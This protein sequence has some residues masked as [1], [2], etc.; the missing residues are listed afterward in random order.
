MRCERT[1]RKKEYL[2]LKVNPASLVFPP[3]LY[4]LFIVLIQFCNFLANHFSVSSRFRKQWE[5]SYPWRSRSGIGAVHPNVLGLLYN[6]YFFISLPV[7][8]LSSNP[9]D[10]APPNEQ[11]NHQ[12]GSVTNSLPASATAKVLMKNPFPFS[13]VYTEAPAN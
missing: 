12:T 8:Y 11:P 1:L 13:A 6:S 2:Y 3:F 7:S 9:V 5:P 10:A 4:H